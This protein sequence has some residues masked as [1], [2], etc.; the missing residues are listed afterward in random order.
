MELSQLQFASTDVLQ[1]QI[2]FVSLSVF[3]RLV[4]VLS[5]LPRKKVYYIL[6][7]HVLNRAQKYTYSD[8]IYYKTYVFWVGVRKTE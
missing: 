3:T 7:E 5:I 1:N 2:I 8:N 6:I 4:A